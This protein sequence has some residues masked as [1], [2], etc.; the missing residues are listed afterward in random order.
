MAQQE[1]GKGGHHQ[2]D[3]QQEEACAG[4]VASL[5]SSARWEQ[6]KKSRKTRFRKVKGFPK[7]TL[8]KATWSFAHELPAKRVLGLIPCKTISAHSPPCRGF[9]FLLIFSSLAHT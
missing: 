6:G 7:V 5:R 2:E 9:I 8:R 4:S 1:V 3:S